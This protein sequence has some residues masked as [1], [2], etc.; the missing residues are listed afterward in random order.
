M[1]DGK[2]VGEDIILKQGGKA[3]D[4]DDL[5]QENRILGRVNLDF[6]LSNTFTYRLLFGADYRTKIR[7][8]WFGNSIL[9]GSQSNGEASRSTLDRF[10]YNIDNTLLFKKKINS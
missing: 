5:S 8:T 7:T 3:V 9:R 2:D 1:V 4:F 6:K 10:R